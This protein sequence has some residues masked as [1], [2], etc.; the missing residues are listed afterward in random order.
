MARNRSSSADAPKR[1]QKRTGRLCGVGRARTLERA[2]RGR[3][4]RYWRKRLWRSPFPSYVPRVGVCRVYFPHRER[5]STAIPPRVLSSFPPAPMERSSANALEVM[6]VDIFR[7]FSFDGEKKERGRLL[8]SAQFAV[9]Y[10]L[11][12]VG[13]VIR[14]HRKNTP[15]STLRQVRLPRFRDTLLRPSNPRRNHTC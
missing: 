7:P 15:L 12:G 5:F 3:T 4:R 14:R 6:F 10:S 1:R 11:Q 9:R 13:R 2:R 8:P